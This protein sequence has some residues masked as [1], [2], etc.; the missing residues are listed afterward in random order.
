[1]ETKLF[2]LSCMGAKIHCVDIPKMEP[3][4]VERLRGAIRV[5]HY[6]R[7]MEIYV[8]ARGVAHGHDHP[9]PS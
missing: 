2:A 1:M 9:Q 8:L 3:T 5:R 6:S 4:M 7:H